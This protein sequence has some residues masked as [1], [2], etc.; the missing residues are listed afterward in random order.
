MNKTCSKHKLGRSSQSELFHG[1]LP[2]I[3]CVPRF[4]IICD[5]I[6]E[7]STR[8]T[9]ISARTSLDNK[10]VLTYLEQAWNRTG[11]QRPAAAD[12]RHHCQHCQ[13][14]RDFNFRIHRRWRAPFCCQR[15][16]PIGS[17]AIF[18]KTVKVGWRMSEDWVDWFRIGVSTATSTLDGF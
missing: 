7:S 11:W 12:S 4:H 17:F 15:H 5:A 1:K 2:L 16:N 18:F 6:I 10:E 9:F 13:L 3:C 14:T 8:W